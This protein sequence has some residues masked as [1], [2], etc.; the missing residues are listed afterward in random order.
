MTLLRE[1]DSIKLRAK[2][3]VPVA[4]VTDI[5]AVA[6]VAGSL[7]SKHFL[8]DTPNNGYYVWMRVDG[9]G[10]DPQVSGRR[11]I[12]VD[13][14]ANDADTVVAGKVQAA[15]DANVEFVATVA[16][17][18]VTVTNVVEGDVLD[19]ADFDSGF[20]I[21]VATAGVD[22]DDII[23]NC[24]FINRALAGSVISVVSGAPERLIYNL[25]GANPDY[26]VIDDN[27]N[28]LVVYTADVTP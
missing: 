12:V 22:A 11:G 17:A 21:A 28:G 4:E 5:T 15:I 27:F 26:V 2:L 7:A 23:V 9:V 1:E 20:T 16:L 18:V 19:A 14:V 10:T 6:D 8:L 13:L 3:P 24:K 25:N